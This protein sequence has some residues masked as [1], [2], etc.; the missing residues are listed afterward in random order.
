MTSEYSITREFVASGEL[1]SHLAEYERQ[2]LLTR[3]TQDERAQSRAEAIAQFP[4]GGDIWLFA[5]GSLI[6]NPTIKIKETRL[7]HLRGYHRRFCMKTVLGRGTPEKPGLMLALD[8]GGSCHGIAYRID[9]A[10]AEEELKLIWDREMIS[11]AYVARVLPMKSA[12]GPIQAI[13]F[14]INRRAEQYVG[15]LDHDHVANLIAQ[16]QGPLGGC[17]EYL[18]QTLTKMTELD[19]RDSHLQHLAELVRKRV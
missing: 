1:E 12:D 4:D 16:S 15:K 7:G 2:G 5:Y 8:H 17:A 13:T 10:I 19:I 18:F 6:W 9:R 11:N 3:S 14:T